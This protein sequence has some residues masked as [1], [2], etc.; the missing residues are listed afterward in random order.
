MSCMVMIICIILTS[1][2]IHECI[3]SSDLSIK[4]REFILTITCNLTACLYKML[5]IILDGSILPVNSYLLN[6]IFHFA[7]ILSAYFWFLYSEKKQGMKY[8]GNK[9]IRFIVLLPIMIFEILSLTGN[10]F[11]IDQTGYI[12]T[13]SFYYTENLLV[14]IYNFF[15]GGKTLY[16][17]LLRKN[18]ENMEE[19][20]SIVKFMIFR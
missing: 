20:F 8:I 5:H 14:I 7:M 10:I 19:Y 18:Y 11:Y 16:L 2:E 17:A 12:R 9:F 15:T 4:T 13:T 3:I 6:H 1:F